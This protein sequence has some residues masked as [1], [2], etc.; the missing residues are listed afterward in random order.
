VLNI[1]VLTEKG[2]DPFDVLPEGW[3]CVT[4]NSGMPVYLHRASRV[5][6]ATKPYFLGT[7]SLRVRVLI[8]IV[9]IFSYLDIEETMAV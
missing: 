7:G 9:G 1:F 2:K 5:C 4:H 3:I 6:T 8:V